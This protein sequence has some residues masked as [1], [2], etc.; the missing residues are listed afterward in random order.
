MV[1]SARIGLVIIPKKWEERITQW[2]KKYSKVSMKECVERIHH[3][4]MS[5]GSPKLLQLAIQRAKE[6][7]RRV[8]TKEKHVLSYDKYESAAYA[9]V[10]AIPTYAAAYNILSQIKQRIPDFEP[11]SILD[12]G[13]GP[14]SAVWA[15]KELY[16]IPEVTAIDTSQDMLDIF[17]TFIEEDQC[18]IHTQRYLSLTVSD[19]LHSDM[20]VSSFTL[21]ELQTDTIRKM[22]VLNLWKQTKDVLILIDR[23]SPVGAKVIASARQEILDYCKEHSE[24]CYIVAPCPHESICPMLT[25]PHKHWCHFSQRYQLIPTMVS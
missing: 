15:A 22:T 25:N 3:S 4:L 21:S 2:V 5:T 18:E 1:F 11:N 8:P 10:R 16:S 7:K 19:T 13:S 17:Q 14:G 23:G 12:F 20:V 24:D 6:E 9:G